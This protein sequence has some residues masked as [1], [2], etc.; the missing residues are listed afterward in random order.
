VVGIEAAVREATRNAVGELFARYPTHHFYYLTLTTTGEVL[1]P[2]LSASSLESLTGDE[3]KWSY[4]DAAFSLFGEHHFDVVR[5]L[6]EAGAGDP[7]ERLAAIERAVRALD[8]DGV[9]DGTPLPRAEM[10]V[11]VEVMPPDHTN[12]ARTI[13]LNPPGPALTAW[14]AEAAEPE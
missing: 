10:I 2:Y 14:L 7:E 9:F 11:T 6:F 13:R 1:T 3:L 12:T 8:A 4:A 5:P